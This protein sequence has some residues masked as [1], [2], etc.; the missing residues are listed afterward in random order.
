MASDPLSDARRRADSLAGVPMFAGM[1]AETEPEREDTPMSSSPWAALAT[2]A[3]SHRILAGE[4]LWHEGDPAD[5]LYVVVTGRLEV[6]AEG[7]TPTVVR[8]LGRGGAVG[9]LALLTASARS[10]GVR[11]RRD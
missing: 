4:W 10:A 6:V 2:S 5:S 7:P 8:T 11:A 1:A 9:E 3:E